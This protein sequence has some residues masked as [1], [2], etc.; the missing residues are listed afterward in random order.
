MRS[1][2][3]G[4]GA[5]EQRTPEQKS[6][7]VTELGSSLHDEWRAPREIK[8]ADGKGTGT[9]EPR[10]KVLVKTD[11]GKEKWLDESKVPQNATELKR[12]DIA[13]TD[14]KDLDPHW[15]YENKAAAEVAMNEVFQAVESGRTLDEAFVEEA[16]ATVHEKWLERNQWVHDPK[17]GNPDLAKPYAELSEKEKEK[18]RAQV[19]KAIRIFEASK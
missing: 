5:P 13:N 17:Y 3:T 8:N 16:S 15:Q 7:M 4:M 11:E 10:I 18:D 12:Q 2:E 9:Y 6:E 19:R 14:F 1:P